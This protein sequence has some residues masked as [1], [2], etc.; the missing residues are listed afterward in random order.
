MYDVFA[1]NLCDVVKTERWGQL[2]FA[3]RKYA[4]SPAFGFYNVTQVT[5]VNVIHNLVEISTP[6]S[7]FTPVNIAIYIY[8]L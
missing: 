3:S 2:I 1:R 5:R 7:G 8:Q 6:A 4:L